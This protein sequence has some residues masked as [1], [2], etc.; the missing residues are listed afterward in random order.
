M[1]EPDEGQRLPWLTSGGGTL[2]PVP[3]LWGAIRRDSASRS[4]IGRGD[5]ECLSR[6]C[7]R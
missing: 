6:S 4:R 7:Q 3:A 2:I 1:P 5:G